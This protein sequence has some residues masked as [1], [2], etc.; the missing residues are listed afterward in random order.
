MGMTWCEVARLAQSTSQKSGRKVDWNPIHLWIQHPRWSIEYRCTAFVGANHW[1][2]VSVLGQRP[3]LG[4]V[5]RC[6]VC[7]PKAVH[8]QAFRTAAVTQGLFLSCQPRRAKNVFFS[9]TKNATIFWP[10]FRKMWVEI[11]KKFVI[12]MWMNNRLKYTQ[13]FWFCRH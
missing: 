12:V 4:D 6:I 9:W 2:N 1:K 8:R 5:T 10:Y 11:E 3:V 13:N 7:K